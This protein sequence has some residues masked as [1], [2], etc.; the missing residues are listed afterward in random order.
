MRRSEQAI[1]NFENALTRAEEEA[2]Q[3]PEKVNN[4]RIEKAR[5][6][7]K[8]AAGGA[9]AELEGGDEEVGEGD[10]ERASEES[11][12]KAL[13]EAKEAVNHARSYLIGELFRVGAVW[14]GAV[15][16]RCGI[17]TK[18]V[19][20]CYCLL[21]SIT[22]LAR[23]RAAQDGG[24]VDAVSEHFIRSF[25]DVFYGDVSSLR[26]TCEKAIRC[27]QGHCRCRM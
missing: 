8:A 2:A 15:V 20:L 13:E 7:K 6:A 23:R 22:F 18:A 12:A 25:T 5:K 26:P 27:F 21:Y 1:G 4:D 24:L 3:G 14:G 16:C 10:W 9:G 17:S 19:V 11:L